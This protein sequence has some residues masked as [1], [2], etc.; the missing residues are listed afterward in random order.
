[1]TTDARFRRSDRVRQPPEFQHCFA[2][3]ERVNGR[4]FRLHAVP[5]AGPRLGLAVA[6]KVDTRAVVRNRIKRVARESFRQQRAGLPN[7]D[8]VLVAKRE[9]ATALSTALREDLSQLWRRALA[10]KPGAP[11]GTMRDA[12][13][14][15]PPSR[16]R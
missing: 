2:Q 9:A 3:G 14:T 13:V 11:A 1:M 16:G 5:A 7:F 8:Y 6:R 15:P 10:L 4:Y 12:C